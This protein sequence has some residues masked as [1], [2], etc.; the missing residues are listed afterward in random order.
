MYG[1]LKIPQLVA[2]LCHDPPRVLQEGHD[3]EETAYCRQLRLERLRVDLDV[4]LGLRRKSA[5]LVDGVV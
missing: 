4:I 2:P 3:D 5:Q 1:P